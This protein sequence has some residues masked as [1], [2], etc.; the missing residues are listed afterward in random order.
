PPLMAQAPPAT[1]AI[2]STWLQADPVAR[3]VEMKLIAGFTNSFGG[4]N[5]NGVREGGLTLTVPVGWKVVLSFT[6]RDPNLPH[7]VEVIRDARP[8]PTAPAAAAF[9]GA[10]G[11][12]LAEGHSNGAGEKI[13]FTAARAGSYLVFCAVPGHGVAG[14]WLRLNVV[15]G[16]SPSLK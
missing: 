6:N 10:A 11:T 15:E 14:M 12:R 4:L 13:T 9:P 3:S 2:D 8:V 5:F 16:G 1:P 7:S